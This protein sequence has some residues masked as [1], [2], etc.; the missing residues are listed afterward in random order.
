MKRI[1]LVLALGTLVAAAPV[2]MAQ[3]D[4]G[5]K[6]FGGSLGVVDPEQLGATFTLGVFA[7]HGTLAPRLG[8]ESRL[9]YWKASESS[10][11]AEVSIR[12]I[13]LGARAKY[14]FPVQSA[15]IQPFAGAGL[16]IHFLNAN[17][18]VPVPPGF[19][20]MSAEASSTEL[21]LDLGGGI[22][23]P[24]GP[25]TDLLAE[26]WFGLVDTANTFMLRAGLSYKLGS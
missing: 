5:F 3:S 11:G 26:T 7:D 24:L 22:A 23:T 6:R 14:Y 4:L 18:V 15:K 8:L 2:A 17:V 12:D 20:P 25:R 21:G 10:F 13:S 9:D 1:A 19:P 16:G